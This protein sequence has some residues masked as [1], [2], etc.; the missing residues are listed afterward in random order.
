MT[1]DWSQIS[2]FAVAIGTAALAIGSIIVV[3]TVLL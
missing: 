1:T 2:S 3:C